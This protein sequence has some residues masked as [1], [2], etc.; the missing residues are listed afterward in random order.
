MQILKETRIII[1][2][3]DTDERDRLVALA[4]ARD[5]YNVRLDLLSSATIIERAIRFVENHRSQP[6][7]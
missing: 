1:D 4:L 7:V 6:E 2:K 3:A 5:T